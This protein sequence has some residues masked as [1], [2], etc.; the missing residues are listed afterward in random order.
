MSTPSRRLLIQSLLAIIPV[1]LIDLAAG[2]AQPSD[3]NVWK[4]F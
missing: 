1:S 2:Q 4:E 3:E